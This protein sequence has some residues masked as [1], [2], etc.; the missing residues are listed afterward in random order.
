MKVKNNRR[1]DGDTQPKSRG[2]WGALL[3]CLWLRR[4]E[5]E[6]HMNLT[7][8]SAQCV[9]ADGGMAVMLTVCSLWF[10]LPFKTVGCNRSPGGELALLSHCVCERAFQCSYWIMTC[11]VSGKGK[12]ITC[13][14]QRASL[15]DWQS[16][17]DEERRRRKSQRVIMKQTTSHREE[18]RGQ[19]D[20]FPACRF[21]AAYWG[22]TERRHN[23]RG[24][25]NTRTITT[26]G[27]NTPTH[28]GWI[29]EGVS[30]RLSKEKNNFWG[31]ISHKT[32][33]EATCKYSRNDKIMVTLFYCAFTESLFGIFKG[34]K[35]WNTLLI[36]P[37]G[38]LVG[39]SSIQRPRTLVTADN[40]PDV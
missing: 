24:A 3:C 34:Q 32:T 9:R 37:E 22:E 39:L 35:L 26:I 17:E 36:G 27:K 7:Q 29:Y 8:L 16:D 30:F 40:Q 18:E 19:L 31:C 20:S 15:S 38:W 33:M 25:T 6:T 14:Y 11:K 4:W 2:V 21:M 10:S 5:Q 23:S 28:H 13:V 12:Q 1:G